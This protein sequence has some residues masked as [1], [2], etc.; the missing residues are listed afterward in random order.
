LKNCADCNYNAYEH[1]ADVQKWADLLNMNLIVIINI[2]NAFLP[3]MDEN[4]YRNIVNFSSVAA[5]QVFLA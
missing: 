1:K 2:F 5:K 3:I 4:N